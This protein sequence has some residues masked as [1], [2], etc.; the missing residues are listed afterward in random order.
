MSAYITRVNKRWIEHIRNNDLESKE[1]PGNECR[2]WKEGSSG[3]CEGYIEILDDDFIALKKKEKR[4][5]EEDT[6]RALYMD[7]IIECE[8]NNEN[9]GVLI[10]GIKN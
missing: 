7:K 2:I 10:Y 6:W 8:S 1:K 3:Y 9:E 5:R 4:W